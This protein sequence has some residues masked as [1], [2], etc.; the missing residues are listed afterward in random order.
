MRWRRSL[1]CVR[2][3]MSACSSMWEFAASRTSEKPSTLGA[4][5]LMTEPFRLAVVL[6]FAVKDNKPWENGSG[7]LGGGM[8]SCKISADRRLRASVGP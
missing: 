8:G 4:T 6:L 3:A 7:F 1:N 5:P 2:L